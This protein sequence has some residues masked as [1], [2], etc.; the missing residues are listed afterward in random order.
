MQ[1]RFNLVVGYGTLV[2]DA[3]LVLASIATQMMKAE[4]T[5][6]LPPYGSDSGSEPSRILVLIVA[7]WT[8]ILAVG[9]LNQSRPQANSSPGSLWF[10]V[11]LAIA[12][13]SYLAP[14]VRDL[15]AGGL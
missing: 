3:Y 12:W 15:F 4:Y 13:M 1:T 14:A 9:C 11:V 2:I 7:T 8:A 10:I 5:R 6:F